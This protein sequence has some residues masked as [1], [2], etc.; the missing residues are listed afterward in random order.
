MLTCGHLEQGP[1]EQLELCNAEFSK[2]SKKGPHL[3]VSGWTA[4]LPS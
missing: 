2:D 3:N 1:L 4:N